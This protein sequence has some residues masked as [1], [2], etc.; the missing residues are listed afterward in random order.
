MAKEETIKEEIDTDLSEE[1]DVT[2][3]SQRVRHKNW[4]KKR[5]EMRVRFKRV[6][7]D[8]ASGM[9]TSKACAKYKWKKEHFYRYMCKY[10]EYRDEYVTAKVMGCD[11]LAD[12]SLDI[13]F[14]EKD[15]SPVR[16]SR[17]TLK[18][19]GIKWYT[20]VTAPRTYGARVQQEITGNLQ[21]TQPVLNVQ[22]ST[23]ELGYTP[24]KA[25]IALSDES[26]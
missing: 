7:S 19:A 2:M 14:G 12:K 22:L 11:A 5:I 13:V 1:K 15:D 25:V 6:C 4:S 3:V 26:D 17:D 8:I 24:P 9:S 10:P 23:G 20:S 18:L 16:V 21:N